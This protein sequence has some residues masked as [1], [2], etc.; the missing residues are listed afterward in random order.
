MSAPT[1]PPAF[2]TPPPSVRD[3]WRARRDDERVGLRFEDAS[4]TWRAHDQA[5][6]ERAALLL[7]LRAPG[8]PFHVGVLLDNVPEFSF[9]L[10]AAAYAGATIVGIN[11]TRRG[12]ELERDIAHSDCR[13]LITEDRYTPLLEKLALEVAP[14]RRFSIDAPRWREAVAAF[15]GAP[16]PDVALDPLAPYLLIFTSGTTGQPKASICSQLRLGGIARTLCAMR[17][18]GPADVSYQ[19]MPM[20]HSNALMAGWAPAVCAG[21]TIVLRRKFSAS[22]FLPDVRK[23]GVSY[24][25]YVGKPLTFVLATPEQPDDANNTLR[26]AFG[27]EAADHDLE[28]FAKRFGCQVIDS[29]GSTEGAVSIARVP[30]MPA[31]SLG[32]GMPGTVILNA[33]TGEE[34]P[35][36][37]FDANGKLQNADEAIGEIANV[38]S[39]PMFEGYYKNTEANSARV[40]NKIYWTGDLGY[41]D[42]RGFLYFAGRDFDW[43]RVDGENFAAAPVE[44]ILTRHP[45]I[46]LAA[47]YGVPDE[48]VGDALMAALVLR[49]GARFDAAGFD[50]FLAQQPDLG[51]K[52]SPRYVRV[53]AELPQTQTN[54][55]LKRELRKQRWEC[56]DPVWQRTK[57]GYRALTSDDA[58]QIRQ[59]FRARG[60]ENVLDA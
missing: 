1:A 53:A 22:G 49:P 9:A 50:A 27:N 16:D 25:N 45:D 52:Q 51:T 21:A 40:R 28:R 55:I 20:F 47:V 37:R 12:A 18:L 26:I 48:E 19:V 23:Y 38:Q 31:G 13:V 59:R 34:A 11:P 56:A 54:K 15:A 43:L 6:L 57:T 29:Y 39:A 7:S 2:T 46:A 4:W 33:E 36:A 35:R 8:E 17:G 60:R 24:F 10:A 30:G 14:E 3:L 44:R 5:A 42:E 41:R 58:A 32:V